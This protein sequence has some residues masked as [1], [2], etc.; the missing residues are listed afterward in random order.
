V[1]FEVLFFRLSQS[2]HFITAPTRSLGALSSEQHR[3]YA[4]AL[5]AAAAALHTISIVSLGQCMHN[6]HIGFIGTDGSSCD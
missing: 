4:P 5:A 3:H 6:Q 1:L 2:S